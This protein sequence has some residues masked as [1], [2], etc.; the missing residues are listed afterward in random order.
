MVVGARKEGGEEVSTINITDGARL[1]FV[2]EGNKC[3]WHKDGERWVVLGP[4]E[5]VHGHPVSRCLNGIGHVSVVTVW[6]SDGSSREVKVRVI[7]DMWDAN[8]RFVSVGEPV[9]G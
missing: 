3:K 9:K 1:P 8:G 7:A 6:K 2:F 4:S 5:K